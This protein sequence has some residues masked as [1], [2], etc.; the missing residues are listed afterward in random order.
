MSRPAARGKTVSYETELCKLNNE[1]TLGLLAVSIAA[2]HVG[3]DKIYLALESFSPLVLLCGN[4]H[5]PDSYDDNRISSNASHMTALRLVNNSLTRNS[6]L[7]LAHKAD[8]KLNGD[9]S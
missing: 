8:A 2:H 6:K 4:L 5:S 1:P 7:H 3:T 9:L